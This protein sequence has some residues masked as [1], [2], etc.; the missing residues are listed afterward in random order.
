MGTAATKDVN[1]IKN[2]VN[3]LLATQHKQQETLV[4][5]IFVLN[6]TRYATQ[7]NRQHITLVMDAVE[8]THQDVTT[9]YNITSSPFTSLKYEQIVL[10]IHSIL[11]NLRASLYYMR[12]VA[13]HAMDY[14]DAART[15]TL[16]PHVFPVEDLQKMLIHIKEALPSTMHLPLSSEDT[17]HFYRYLCNH[18]LIADKQFL[19]LN[20]LPIWGHAQQLKIYEV[21]NLIIPHGNL[22]ACYKINSKYLG[23]TCDETKAVEM[24]EQQFNTCQQADGQFCSINT[25]LQPF[26]NPPSCFASIY[27]KKKKKT[28]GGIE[29][30]CSLQI[31]NTSRVTIPTQIA[32]NVWI[33]TSASTAVLTGIMIICPEEAPSFIKTQTPI[34]ILHLPL[35]SCTTSQ[36][37]HLPPHYETDHLTINKSLNTANFNVMNISSPEFRIWRHLEDHWN[38]TQLHLLVNIP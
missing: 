37:F 17:L 12:Q 19:L 18:V 11:A 4:H 20:D 30:R 14:I 6:V 33:L 13:M 15:C 35:A 5:S 26:S 22:S 27:T 38:G 3:Q 21:F 29:K 9:L 36:H 32:P 16:S 25:P 10:H 1:S 34:H 8:R 31:T 2:R 24:S 23:I 7:V 28:K